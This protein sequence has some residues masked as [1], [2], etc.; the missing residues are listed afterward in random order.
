MGEDKTKDKS[1]KKKVG[2]GG[3]T[4]LKIKVQRIK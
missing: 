3:E 2:Q 1:T 4:R